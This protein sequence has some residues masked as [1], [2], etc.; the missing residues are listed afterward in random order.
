MCL[1]D[2]T[3]SFLLPRK[4]TP[5]TTRNWTDGNSKFGPGKLTPEKK[6]KAR[7]L[8]S[9]GWPGYAIAQEIGVSPNAVYVFLRKPNEEAQPEQPQS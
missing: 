1:L 7:E 9:L 4:G 3:T 6:Q 5:M 2:H 8:R